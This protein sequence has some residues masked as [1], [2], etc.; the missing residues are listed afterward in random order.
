MTF[1]RNSIFPWLIVLLAL[2]PALLFAYLGQFSRMIADDYYTIALGQELGAWDGMLYWYNSWS[3]SYTHFFLRSAMGLLD[4]LAP[5]ITPPVIVALWL[6]GLSWLVFQGLACLRIGNSRRAL[7]IAI[8]ALIIAAS[9]NAFYSPQSFYWHAASIPYTLPIALLTIY[10]AMAIWIA[11]RLGRNSSSLLGIIAGGMLC[12]ISAG[13]SEVFLVFQITFLTLCL[14]MSFAFLRSPLR[15]PYVLSFGTGWL[16]T[17]IGLG[18]TVHAPGVARRTAY[19]VQRDGQPDRSIP[20]LI[21]E[22]LNQTFGYIGNPQAFAGFILLMGI[23]LLVMLVKYKPRAVFEVSEPVELVAYSLWLGL[24][25][26][27]LWL[28]LLWGGHTSDNPQFLGIWHFIVL[29]VALI[30]SFLVMLWQRNRLNARLRKQERGLLI[31][32]YAIAFTFIFVLL[33]ALMHLG[34]VH[35]LALTYLFTSSLVFFGIITRQLLS[36]DSTSTAQKFGFLALCSYG[37]VLVLSTTFI[38][39]ILFV[40]GSGPVKP[41]ILAPIAYLLVLPGLL[42]GAYIGYLV[43]NYLPSSQASQA[44][45]RFVKLGSLAIILLIGSSM[46]LVQVALIPDFQI[47][48]REWDARHIEIIAQRDSGQTIIKVSPLTY[49]IAH[50]LDNSTLL[51]QERVT[52][53]YA[54]DYYGVDSIVAAEP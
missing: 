44:W 25:F 19:I 39:T 54:R 29:N 32:C 7:A 45:I 12:F 11:Q 36:M 23:G 41:R 20:I 8:S 43:K 42:W 33:F 13:L 22:T 24:V 21:S 31:I 4:T 40:A 3:G 30:L 51:D 15:R 34:S 53:L 37:F 47:Y 49:D 14:L 2:V 48:A 52:N 10:T 27:L 28:P 6:F 50:Y 5:V 46:V 1:K 35:H 38:F 9:I 26:Q 16:A 18:I 17:L